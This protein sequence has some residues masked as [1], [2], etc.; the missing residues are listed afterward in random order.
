MRFGEP[1]CFTVIFP[2]I[3]A[4]LEDLHVTDDPRKIGYFAGVIEGL[5]AFTT[6]ATVLT[7][8]RISDRIG[9]K[10]VLSMGLTGVA[11]SITAFGFSKS[12]WGLVVAR[13]LSGALNGN[14]VV[15]KVSNML[16]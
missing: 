7:W 2:F 14:V 16:S 5:F 11:C 13:C 15:V 9:R 6:F 8:G 3:A 1:I 4:F 10:P 12:F